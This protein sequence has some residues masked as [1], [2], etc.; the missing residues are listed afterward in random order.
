MEVPEAQGKAPINSRVPRLRRSSFSHERTLCSVNS[1]IRIESDRG[2]RPRM[3]W[4]MAIASANLS[5][6]SPI[7]LSMNLM[8]LMKAMMLRRDVVLQDE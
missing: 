8:K 2:L 6:R 7:T 1:N 5:L 4:V 3:V